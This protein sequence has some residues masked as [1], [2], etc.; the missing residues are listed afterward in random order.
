MIIVLRR[1]LQQ[2]FLLILLVVLVVVAIKAAPFMVRQLF[3]LHY[4]DI[5]SQQAAERDVDPFL[6]AAIINVESRW[7]PNAI[8]PKGANGLMQLMPATAD[9][10][11]SKTGNAG[12][13]RDQLL[14]PEVNIELGTWYIADLLKQFDNNLA[15]AL[16]AYNGGRGNVR[17]WLDTGIWDGSVGHIDRIPFGETRRY[18][19][20]VLRHYQVYR[21][22]Y[23]WR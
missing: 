22:L 3:P 15:V 4:R 14:K 19:Q 1:A 13:T 9:W 21:N 17:N 8:S 6:I 12:T 5:I 11:A 20:K 23:E 10:A 18:V 2:L 7:K 16:A